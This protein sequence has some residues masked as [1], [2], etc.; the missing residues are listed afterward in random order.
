M[1]EGRIGDVRHVR[2]QYLQDWISDPEAPLSWRLRKEKAGSG[3][4]GDIGAHIV[5]LTQ[6][7][8]GLTITEVSGQLE[9]FVKERPLAT[10]HAGLSGT[11][12]IERGSVTVD[13]AAVFL[14]R[15]KGRQHSVSTR[16]PAS[17][18]DAR[19]AFASR[20]TARKE[21]SRSTSRT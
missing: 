12:G 5:D 17:P 10:E 7:I 8:T 3:A 11:A 9:T 14:A 21:A 16:P 4:L 19:T 20:S 6:H 1:Q 13:D 18:P 15:F 2:A